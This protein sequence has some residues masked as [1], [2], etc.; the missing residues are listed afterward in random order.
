MDSKLISQ[1]NKGTLNQTKSKIYLNN[2][3]GIMYEIEI[4]EGSRIS[5]KG[6]EINNE[7][8]F[9][10]CSQFECLETEQQGEVLLV[11]LRYIKP[12]DYLG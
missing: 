10:R 4:P 6:Y 9:P 1:E 5:I 3:K 7:I 11:K 2:K 12:V 8:V